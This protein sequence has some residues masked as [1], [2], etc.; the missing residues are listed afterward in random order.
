MASETA[1][2][3]PKKYLLM[4]HRIRK[5]QN[6]AKWVGTLYII[7]MFAMAILSCL[8]LFSFEGGAIGAIACWEPFKLLTKDGDI[9]T[10]L[11]TNAVSLTIALLYAIMLLV[12]LI[13]FIS[14]LTNMGWL[15]KKKA[16]KLYGFNRNMYAMDDIEKAYCTMFKTV[17]S[18]HFIIA[19]LVVN[20]QINL[21]LV[22]A[23]LG[24]GL[25]FHF[26]C[27]LLAGNTSLFTVD[28]QI[29]EER[30]KVGTFSVFVR[31]LIQIVA[32]AG[33]VFFF[34]KSSGS[35]VA[36][37]EVLLTD[38]FAG[39]SADMLV[40]VLPIARLLLLVLGIVMLSYALG[41]T[42]FE[43][44]G[45]ETSGRRTFLW[46]SLFA[47]VISLGTA[48]FMTLH[49]KTPLSADLMILAGV[50]LGALVL[51]ICLKRFPRVKEKNPDE[52]D[53]SAYLKDGVEEDEDEETAVQTQVL[54]P[55]YI[56]LPPF[57]Q[58]YHG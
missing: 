44:S 54:P 29:V 51:E 8:Q 30:R 5:M 48:L 18:V 16:S 38:G 20:V 50:S 28:K 42:E 40:L 21:L 37:V 39:I 1:K 26:L 53:A 15:Y 11:K 6:R 34:V 7:A 57:G 35:F 33:F 14:A 58:N 49:Y 24:L 13:S 17:V 56:P 27:G 55:V 9:V 52:V 45:R 4:K 41:T 10:V 47:F 36:L 46:T 2:K 43:P 12:V 25:F 22:V 3:A 31:N 23:L 19:S 32:S